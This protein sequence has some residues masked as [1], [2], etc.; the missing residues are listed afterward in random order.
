MVS[1][2]RGG[3]SNVFYPLSPRLT[4]LLGTIFMHGGEEDLYLLDYLTDEDSYLSKEKAESLLQMD[5]AKRA[6]IVAAEMRRQFQFRGLLAL[7]Q[8]EPSWLLSPLKGEQPTT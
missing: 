6:A 4:V 8:V 3:Y 2:G 7:D 1:P 5:G